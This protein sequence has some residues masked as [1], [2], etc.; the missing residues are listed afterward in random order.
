M[1]VSRLLNRNKVRNNEIFFIVMGENNYYKIRYPTRLSFKNE[2]K[3]KTILTDKN[4]RR[5]TTNRS[6]FYN[7]VKYV[8]KRVGK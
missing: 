7:V 3:M 6:S 5:L 1:T 4:L 2:T 8:F